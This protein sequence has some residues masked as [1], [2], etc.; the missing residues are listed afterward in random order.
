MSHNH[1]AAN[2][3]STSNVKLAFLLNLGFAILE[4]LGGIFTGSTAIL[5]DA[6]HDFG[7]SFAL[8][9]SYIFEKVGK[10][11]PTEKYTYGFK[12]L[13]LIGAFINII[14]LSSGTVFV[15]K[16]AIEGLMNPQAVKADGM[17]ILAI[18]G[19]VINGLSVLRMKGSKKILDR[20]VMMHLLED[21]LGWIA[22]LVVSVVIFFTNWYI[23]D[24]I[25]SLGICVIIGKNIYD[26]IKTSIS[27]VLQSVPDK[28]LYEEIRQH[29]LEMPEIK[30]IE[31]SN[32]WTID[33][34]EHVFTANIE[35]EQ[36]AD[37]SEV[38]RKIKEMLK[39]ESIIQSTIEIK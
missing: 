37:K 25:L 27:I 24:S 20:T 36:I 8:A 16:E 4:I 19:I 39:N 33:G 7:D 18:I 5:S 32:M 13:S 26:N 34:E 10:K 11:Q 23:L 28:E 6:V 30:T 31:K 29:I 22:V 2:R 9:L 17:F 12:R 1:S 14:V 15:F 3:D 35:T 38:L 21:L